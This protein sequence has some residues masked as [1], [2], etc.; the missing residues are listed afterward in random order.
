[1]ISFIVHKIVNPLKKFTK[2]YL[3][4][5]LN[6]F[7]AGLSKTASFYIGGISNK[8]ERSKDINRVG[9][10]SKFEGKSGELSGG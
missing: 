9:L 3:P 4:H 1:M 10:N 7:S 8:I 2:Y 5:T 6:W